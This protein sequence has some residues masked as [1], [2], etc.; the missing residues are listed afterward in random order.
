LITGPGFEPSIVIVAVS[1][2]AVIGKSSRT[3]AN[4]TQRSGADKAE[5]HSFI[6]VR[7]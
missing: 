1:V 7:S 4:F 5:L 3:Q 2:R 6:F